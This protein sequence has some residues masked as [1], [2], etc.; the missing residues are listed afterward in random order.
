MKGERGLA[1]IYALLALALGAVITVP[2]LSLMNTGL[3]AAQVNED[4]TLELYAADAGIDDAIWKLNNCRL[5]MDAG[6]QFNYYYIDPE[7]GLEIDYFGYLPPSD[8]YIPLEVVQIYYD[9]NDI[10]GYQVKVEILYLNALSGGT[11]RV[12]STAYET[13]ISDGTKVE[14]I[15][16][17]FVNLRAFQSALVSSGSIDF[18][19]DTFVIGGDILCGGDIDDGDMETYLHLSEGAEVF[20]NVPKAI[21]DTY[22][23]SPE[24]LAEKAL[25]Y[26]NEAKEGDIY[27]TGQNLYSTGSP[28]GSMYIDGNLTVGNNQEVEINGTVYVTG[29][30]SFGNNAYLSGNCKLV[31]EGDIT[32]QNWQSTGED[33]MFMIFSIGGSIDLGQDFNGRALIYAPTGDVTFKNW[34]NVLGS[35][36]CG[37][38]VD[39]IELEIGKEFTITYDPIYS[40]T[41]ELPGVIVGALVLTYSIS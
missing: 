13:D 6:M 2:L 31:A 3:V 40:D 32:F 23:P 27:E 12:T 25:E 15:I 7:T 14:T 36:I 29:S 20:E 17:S 5:V 22:F 1:L 8:P 18:K 10:N 30:I 28:Y 41:F 4:K 39:V 34:A 37:G 24:E 21:M 38:Q 16:A 9:I 26:E 19:K 11:Y 35:V 33:S